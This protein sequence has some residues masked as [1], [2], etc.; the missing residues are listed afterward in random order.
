VT[1]PG[2]RLRRE[3]RFLAGLIR[4]LA[5]VRSISAKS[6]RLICDDLETAV[7][8]WRDRPAIS[9]EGQTISY[10]ELDALA[11]RFAH[12][13]LEEGIG[14][15]QTVAVFLPN[16]IEYLA[17]WYG[18]T[19]VGVVAA[20]VGSELAGH[21]LVHCLAICGA[22]HCLIDART[23]DAFADVG[24]QLDPSIRG[25]RLDPPPGETAPPGLIEG[26]AV[27]RPSRAGRSGITADQTALLI[28]TSGTTGLPKAA[29]I[30]H[31]RAQLYMRGFAGATGARASDRLYLALPLH[32][33]TGG[34]CAMGAALLNGASVALRRS[35]SASRF[36]GEVDA[37]GATMFVYIGEL[38]RYLANQPAGPQE[39]RH[40]LR[41]AFGNGLRPDV[42][43]VLEGRFGVPRVLEFYGSTEGNVSMFN[44]DGRLG[45]IG[46][47]PRWLPGVLNAAL[48]RLDV[49][50]ETPIRGADGLCVRAGDG[51]V[52]ECLG[53]IAHDARGAYS[54]YVD[55]AA[56]D[57]K[58]LRDVFAPGDRWF[59][60]GDLMRQ[61]AAGY[62][63]FVDRV[64]DTFRWKGENV[65]TGEVAQS[66][67]AAPGVIEANVYGV[68]VGGL[69]GRAGMAALVARDGL[70]LAALAARI[71][72]DLPPYAR[73][74]FLRLLPRLDT[75]ATFKPRKA[76]L[77]ADGFD[78]ALAKGPLFFRN[79]AGAFVAL[80][81]EL[82]ARIISGEERI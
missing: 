40:R 77:V 7:D 37:E 49:E 67:L 80:T 41:L 50:S 2:G 73:P 38:C 56:T 42:W 16:R 26:R 24:G 44:F 81:P 13:A 65:S 14:R 12:W 58:V 69:D 20:L 28:F 57:N 19:K 5:R 51:E 11:N 9:F 45:A 82:H 27:E 15:G 30:T 74:I 8:R 79:H 34:L 3:A 43:A 52:G 62:F 10:G 18:L 36:W 21:A 47:A 39:R 53:R 23:A 46:R 32:H 29:R 48:V 33:A 55:R 4:T 60:T 6:T 71:D 59:A 35:F 17:A 63:Y 72:A 25:W 54:G 75:T 68:V 64:G 61:D 70:D 76:E 78:P 66:L 31:M 22:R 1:A